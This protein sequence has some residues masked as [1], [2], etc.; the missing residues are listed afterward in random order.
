MNRGVRE[1]IPDIGI[2]P[3]VILL[4]L[5]LDLVPS[6]SLDKATCVVYIFSWMMNACSPG[7]FK[8]GRDLRIA[9]GITSGIR[10]I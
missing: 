9:W 8:T 1:L 4:K 3:E 7:I 2:I 5:F 6:S 10:R